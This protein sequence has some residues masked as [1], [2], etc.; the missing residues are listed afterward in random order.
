M[1][2][3]TQKIS[4]EN[5]NVLYKSVCDTW[6]IKIADLLLSNKN[7]NVIEVENTLIAEAYSK[8]DDSQKKLIKKYLKLIEPKNLFKGIEDYKSFCKVS[9]NKELKLS[10][11]SKGLNPNKLLAT[12]K[13]EQ[14]K[15]YFNEQWTP[16]WNNVNEYKYS[17]YFN[18]NTSS[19][20]VGFHVSYTFSAH[21]FGAVCFKTREISDFVGKTFYNEVYKYLI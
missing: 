8:A 14:I 4:K 20:S 3:T 18:L 6:K 7:C 21:S 17:P 5:L 12:D 19:G 13:L 2:N 11:Y 16:D 1:K 9:K 15:L 10:D